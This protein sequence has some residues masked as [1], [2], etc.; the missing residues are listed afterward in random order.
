MRT[1]SLDIPGYPQTRA[2]RE[3]HGI[4]PGGP[5]QSPRLARAAPGGNGVAQSVRAD[6]PVLQKGR[7][8]ESSRQIPPSSRMAICRVAQDVG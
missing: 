6:L 8:F 1:L 5:S 4:S 2:F 3:R 7:W